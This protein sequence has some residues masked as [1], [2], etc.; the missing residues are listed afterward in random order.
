MPTSQPII[1]AIDGH[2]SCGKSTLAKA[3]AQ[4]LGYVYVDTGAMYRA[5]TLYCLQH[6]VALDNPAAVAEALAHIHIDLRVV[7]GENRTFL[8]GADVEEAIRSMEISRLVSHVSALPAVRRAMVQQQQ[9]IGARKGVVMDGR[10]IGTVV[11]PAAELKLFLTASPEVRSRRRYE[12]LLAQ[13]NLGAGL[14]FCYF[15]PRAL[16]GIAAGLLAGYWAV[17]TFVPVRDFPLEKAALAARLGTER[18]TPAQIRAAYEATTARVTGRYEPG[19]NVS[20]HFD[21]EHLPGRKWDVYW[22]PEGIVST[23]PAIATARMSSS[24]RVSR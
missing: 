7:G 23:L 3:L 20:N 18:P 22:D 15:R 16:A 11:F 12:E 8:N 14:L 2:S 1:I 21:F 13:G 5:V 9:A 17:M 4:R 6:Q 24:S 10:D 19:L